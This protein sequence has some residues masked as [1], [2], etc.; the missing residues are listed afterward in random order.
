MV[1]RGGN[2]LS[3]VQARETCRVLEEHAESVVTLRVKEHVRRDP[4]P[5]LTVVWL[6]Q[7]WTLCHL[8]AFMG[9]ISLDRKPLAR[10]FKNYCLPLYWQ[11]GGSVISVD[12]Q[13]NCTV[14]WQA[15]EEH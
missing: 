1:W 15:A 5:L 8:A 11:L 9:V 12:E 3:S 7:R 2:I 10:T 6:V 4:P 13:F 14:L